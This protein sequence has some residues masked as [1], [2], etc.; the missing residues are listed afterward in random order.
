MTS[1][2]EQAREIALADMLAS[3]ARKG[4]E[5]DFI[6]TDAEVTAKYRSGEYDSLSNVRCAL[7]GL[8]SVNADLLEALKRIANDPYQFGHRVQRMKKIAQDAISLAEKS[9]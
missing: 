5:S 4:P 3:R 2:I 1:L 9:Q 6:S 7:A 8:E